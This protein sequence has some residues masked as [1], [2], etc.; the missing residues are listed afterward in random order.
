MNNIA[1]RIAFPFYVFMFL[2]CLCCSASVSSVEPE[3]CDIT[4]NIYDIEDNKENNKFEGDLIFKAPKGWKIAKIPKITAAPEQSQKSGIKLRIKEDT[5]AKISD[6]EWIVP[7][8][9]ELSEDIMEELKQISENLPEPSPLPLNLKVKIL[10]DIAL[11]S[12][13]CTIVSQEFVINLGTNIK[14]TRKAERKYSK[15][16]GNL[17]DSKN[18]E[19]SENPD[20]PQALWLMMLIGFLGGLLLNLMPCVLPVILL[21]VRSFLS[22]AS[23]LSPNNSKRSV[24]LGAIFGNYTSFAIFTAFLIF[25]KATGEQ[26][27]WGMHFQNPYFLKTVAIILFLLCLY[28]LEILQIPLFLKINSIRKQVFWESFISSIMTVIFAI[29]CTAPF[30]GTAAAFAIQGSAWDMAIVFFCIS[31][32]FSA[33]YFAIGLSQKMNKAP[34]NTNT[35]LPAETLQKYGRFTKILANAGAMITLVWIL[36]LL[37]AHIGFLGIAII[38]SIFAISVGLFIRKHSTIA[39]VLLIPAVFVED[40]TQN[41]YNTRNTLEQKASNDIIIKEILNGTNSVAKRRM[42]IINVSADWCLTCK[43]NKINVLNSREIQELIEEKNV[44]YIEGDMTHKNDI[45]MQ[46]IKKRGRVG[47]PFTIVLGPGNPKGIVLSE[48][49]NI[50]EIRETIRAV[51]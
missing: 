32:E 6:T 34:Q 44:L 29:P 27:G 23:A 51:E 7:F 25:L 45:L 2:I 8:Y 40:I 18:P 3:N 11:C 24:I 31:T 5:A 49:P 15:N 47:I 17:G 13:I 21:K 33:P 42:V 12:D 14:E 30:L 28:S 35:T 16:S 4:Y 46:I 41:S 22:S 10:A 48:M 26:I 36:Y 39:L 50:E 1:K 20:T 9:L 43:Y 37:K 38:L 19:N